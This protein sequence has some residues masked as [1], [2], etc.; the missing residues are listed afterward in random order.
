M[1]S[2]RMAVTLFLAVLGVALPAYVGGSPGGPTGMPGNAAGSRFVT[3]DVYVTAD[4]PLAAYQLEVLTEPGPNDD[5]RRGKSTIVGVEGG[6]APF[7]EPPLYD[8]AALAV[9]R[10]VI[11]AFDVDAALPAGR[12]RVATLHMHETGVPV[13]YR[14]AV[15]AAADADGARITP[16]TDLSLRKELD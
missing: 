8:P 13:R 16:T 3:V 6:V 11:A 2:I 14:V 10:I 5:T 4:T 7:S 1:T 15:Q 9:G 12:H